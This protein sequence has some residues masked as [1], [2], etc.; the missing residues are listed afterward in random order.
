VL[1]LNPVKVLLIE[2]CDAKTWTS[3]L[4]H[5]QEENKPKVILS[6][7]KPLLLITEG[8]VRKTVI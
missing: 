4:Q 6:F 3:W 5:T 8:V 2:G 1:N 7:D